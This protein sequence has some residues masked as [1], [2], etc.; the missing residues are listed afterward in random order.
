MYHCVTALSLYTDVLILFP[1]CCFLLRFPLSFPVST[2]TK[3][4]LYLMVL[5]TCCFTIFLFYFLFK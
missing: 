3:F 4:H 5:E 1:T 2:V